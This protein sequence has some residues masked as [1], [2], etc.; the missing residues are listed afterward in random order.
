MRERVSKNSKTCSQTQTCH[1]INH[2]I[3]LP[4]T[5][6]VLCSAHRIGVA[7]WSLPCH[8]FVGFVKDPGGGRTLY[9][10]ASSLVARLQPGRGV[11]IAR[12]GSGIVQ[13]KPALAPLGGQ[14]LPNTL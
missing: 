7:L 9:S 12:F 5:W 14:L 2:N 8:G 6:E 13:G 1:S 11:A 10:G 3:E 4:S